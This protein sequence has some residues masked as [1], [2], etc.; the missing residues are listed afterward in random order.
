MF[1]QALEAL[2]YLRIPF[3]PVMPARLRVELVGKTVLFESCFKS[4]IGFEQRLPLP[5]SQVDI[6]A[7]LWIRGPHQFKRITRL[8]FRVPK[9]AEDRSYPPPLVETLDVESTPW[10][11]DGRAQ[12]ADEGIQFRMY[13]RKIDGRKSAHRNPNRR[14]AAAYGR[15]RKAALHVGNQVFRDLV[16]VPILWRFHGIHVIREV[17]FRHHENYA[18][19]C[20]L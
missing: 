5:G 11:V 2:R 4:P 7:G 6:R 12:R 13:K 9:G 17:A 18:S 3:G 10:H 16:L 20:V 14:A 8:P 15:R 19:S 1:Q